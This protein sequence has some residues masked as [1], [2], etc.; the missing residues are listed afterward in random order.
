MTCPAGRSR[1]SPGGFLSRRPRRAET[2]TWLSGTAVLYG[3]EIPVR[4]LA[5]YRCQKAADARDA[6]VVIRRRFWTVP[7]GRER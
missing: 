7:G 2:A 3:Q 4:L 1:R 6:N 5:K